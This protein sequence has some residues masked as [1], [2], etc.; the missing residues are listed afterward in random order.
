M[1]NLPMGTITLL[2][3]DIEGSTQLLQELG[4]DYAEVLTKLMSRGT[5]FL[6]FSP[7]PL[8]AS[9]RQ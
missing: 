8:M 3:A 7:A 9:Q 2:F 5:P 4:D 6:W 1:R